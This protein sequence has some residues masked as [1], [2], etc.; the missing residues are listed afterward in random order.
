LD[1][2]YDYNYPDNLELRPGTTKHDALV[3][4]VLDRA[5]ASA[6]VMSNRHESWREIDHVLTGYIPLDEAEKAVKTADKRRPVS[7]VFPYSYAILETVLS[8]LCAAFFQSPIFRYTGV[9]PEDV[10]GATLLEHVIDVHVNK[11][12]VPLNLHTFFRDMLVHGFGAVAPV[13]IKKTTKTNSHQVDWMSSILS[14]GSVG[15]A[16]TV[17]AGNGLTNI[18]PYTFLP[19]PSVACQDLQKG[20]FVG[21]IEHT[22]LMNM[23]AEEKNS[24]GE[25]FNVR[26]LKHLAAKQTAV[27]AHDPSGRN[28]KHNMTSIENDS[29]VNPVDKITM[30]VKLIPAD[31]G[32]GTNKYPEKWLLTVAADC[33]LIEAKPLGLWHDMFP[34]AIGA[35][36]F[37]GYSTAPVSRLEMLFGLQGTLD[38]LFNA[39]ITNVRKAINDVLIYDPFLINGNDLKNPEEGKLVRTR[40]PAWGKGVKDSIMQLPVSDVTQG[41]IADSSFIVQWMQRIGAADDGSMGSLRQG[42]PERLT[43]EEFQGTRQGAFSRLN[44]IVQVIS[45]QGLNDISEFF[46]AHTQQFMED[47]TYVQITGDWLR[48]L[49]AEYGKDAPTRY[50]VSPKDLSI[51]YDVLVS[52]GTIPGSNYSHVWEKMFEK[53]ASQPELAQK[54]DLVRIFKH[55]AR[56]N[57]VKNVDDFIRTDVQPTA[58][59]QEQAQQGNMIPIDQAMQEG[60]I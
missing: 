42:G 57:G 50:R 58:Q 44:R 40:R 41:H 59:V 21:W 43:G 26:Y 38:W 9:G 27:M 15:N 33:V 31:H 46:A 48:Q 54:F 10:I 24:N 7:I 12:K 6:S 55:I 49:Q 1:V 19:D 56:N 25:L 60:M 30:Y 23:L 20:E 16:Q 47:D 36:E 17:F 8:Y 11:T 28:T 32:L 52:E 13:W 39:H 35:P 4:L 51:A 45:Y 14:G 3:K 37:D 53:V 2:K 18:D 34:V 29:V 22:N 5:R